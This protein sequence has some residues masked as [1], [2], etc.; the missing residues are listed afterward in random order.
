MSVRPRSK[1]DMKQ[2]LYLKLSTPV[3]QELKSTRPSTTH[4]IDAA[5]TPA[6]TDNCAGASDRNKKPT[7]TSVLLSS[8]LT[9]EQILPTSG[10]QNRLRINKRFRM[11][12]HSRPQRIPNSTKQVCLPS[13]RGLSETQKI[14]DES[15]GRTQLKLLVRRT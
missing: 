3:L 2:R 1:F 14:L 7:N 8:I 9:K 6:L 15:L 13:R 5:S 10:F 4:L 11:P 12:R